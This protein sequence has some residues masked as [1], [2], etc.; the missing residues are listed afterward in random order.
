MYGKASCK[1]GLPFGQMLK[2]G[3]ATAIARFDV[4]ATNRPHTSVYESP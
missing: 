4:K 2:E 1:K 3:F